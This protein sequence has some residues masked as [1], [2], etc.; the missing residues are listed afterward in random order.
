MSRDQIRISLEAPVT[1]AGGNGGSVIRYAL[2]RTP[3][4]PIYDS[5]GVFSDKPDAYTML[6]DGYNPVAMLA[7]NNNK[8]IADRIFGKAFIELTIMKGLTFT[9]NV[10]VDITNSNQRRFD[11]TYGT[12]DR[13]NNINLLTVTDRKSESLTL[14]NFANYTKAFDKHH[15]NVLVGTEAIKAK[16][17]VV[18]SSEKNFP[19]QTN[20][21]VYLGQGLGVK[22]HSESNVSNSLLSFF[23]K[24]TYDF[25]E[26]Y[27]ATATLR[28]DGSSRFGRITV[29]V[30]FIQVPWVG[31][32]TKNHF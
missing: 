9:S 29:G 10:G 3:A 31:E 21:L 32:S 15:L 26:K 16:N 13:I 2:F 4:I 24:A 28:R 20:S 30:L 14:S 1:A 7:Y 12:L 19:D 11:R 22:D 25:D 18:N 23:G 8:L 27:L 17:Y 6:G 5:P